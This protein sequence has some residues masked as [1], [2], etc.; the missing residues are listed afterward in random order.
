MSKNAE[1][2][3]TERQ[4]IAATVEV[5]IPAEQVAHQIEQTYKEYAR[6]VSVPG[7]R[8]GNV[9]RAFLDHRFGREIFLEEARDE[10]QRT[11][12]PIALDELELH[13]VSRP[14]MEVV[15]FGENDPFVFRAR[16]D[17]LPTITLPAYQGLEVTVP[18]TRPV[19]DD[20]VDEALQEVQHQFAV[21]GEREGDTVAEG[22]LV[23]VK[24]GDQAWDVRATHESPITRSLV[25]ARV[26]DTVDVNDVLAS[27]ES[28]R[29][30]LEI[31]GLRQV[32]L[33]EISDEL[34]KDAGY[35]SLEALKAEIRAQIAQRRADLHDQQIDGGLLETI[36]QK[37]HIPL[38]DRFVHDLV[39]EE[40]DH[41]RESM[42]R[43]GSRHS[44]AEY[45]EKLEKSEQEVREEIRA[46]IERRLRQ[47]LVL[48]KLASDLAISLDDAALD[49]LAKQDAEKLDEDPLRFMARLKAEDRWEGYRQ[50]KTNDRIFA[51]L[52]ET[53][54]IREE[55]SA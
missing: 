28:V 41:L 35:D 9:P 4:E 31:T 55:E 2:Q 47:E 29:M 7:F 27:G 14:D 52:R 40:L 25:G 38:P 44:F 5:S 17:T 33:P 32:I 30:T 19:S 10:L 43:P 16:F 23:Q 22:D 34:G 8:K 1:Y 48:G 24:S 50:R 6:E 21:L 26:A 15:S 53:A 13:P 42:K 36:L 45:L 54:V 49:A 11:F 39:E 3:I 46:S 20:D 37:M 12:L 51:T 18:A